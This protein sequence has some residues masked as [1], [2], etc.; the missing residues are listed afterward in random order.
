MNE[1]TKLFTPF[2]IGSVELKNRLFVPGMG[3]NLAEPNGEAGPTL[4]KYY[5]ER[6]KGGFGLIITECTAITKEGK[7]LIYECGLWDDSLIPSYQKLTAS[8]HEAGAKIFQQIRHTGR[9]TE[10]H[11]TEGRELQGVSPI[12]C[13]SCQTMPHAMTTQ[14]VYKMIDTYVQA[15]VRPRKKGF[16]GIEG[17]AS[18]G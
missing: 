14:E 16:D 12:P 1:F 9:E 8:V 13:P 4:I 6:A 5:T 2:K 7:S 17:H 15:A 10:L 18:H 11:Y 3:T